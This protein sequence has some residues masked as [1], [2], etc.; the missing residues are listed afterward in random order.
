MPFYMLMNSIYRYM[1]ISTIILFSL[2]SSNLSNPNNRGGLYLTCVVLNT[3][4]PLTLHRDEITSPPP[5]QEYSSA[6]YFTTQ[7]YTM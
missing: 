2:F 7:Y 1:L 4:R 5:L 3:K 6:P